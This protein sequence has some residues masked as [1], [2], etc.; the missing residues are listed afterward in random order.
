MPGWPFTLVTAPHLRSGAARIWAVVCSAPTYVHYVY[1]EEEAQRYATQRGGDWIETITIDIS[2][3]DGR[4]LRLLAPWYE[5]DIETAR[6]GQRCWLCHRRILP[7]EKLGDVGYTDTPSAP[8]ASI[9]SDQ[10]GA[11]H[12]SCVT[13]EW[14]RTWRHDPTREATEQGERHGHLT[15][16][17]DDVSH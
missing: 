5:A 2:A 6:I 8:R 15:D 12:Y 14:E 4:T 11:A 16:S 3:R 9:T 10:R 17:S 1:T 13:R 7:G